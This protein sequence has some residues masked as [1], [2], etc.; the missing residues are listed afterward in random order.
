MITIRMNTCKWARPRPRDT[1]AQGRQPY[2]GEWDR[3]I[4][5]M[6][7]IMKWMKWYFL[8]MISSHLSRWWRSQ[9]ARKKS[10]VPRHPDHI[11]CFQCWK[12]Y[13]TYE[14][15]RMVSYVFDNFLSYSHL[16]PSYQQLATPTTYSVSSAGNNNEYKSQFFIIFL[17]IF[18]FDWQLDTPTT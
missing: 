18:V 13:W 8:I 4:Y 3:T 14:H 11:L 17:H 10:S 5:N 2:L 1:R 6:I 15:I 12:L 9:I 7:T 16:R